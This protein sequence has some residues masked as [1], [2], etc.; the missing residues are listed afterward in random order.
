MPVRARTFTWGFGAT[1]RSPARLAAGRPVS[2][3]ADIAVPTAGLALRSTG[4]DEDPGR[5]LAD[6]ALMV[7]IAGG[8]RDAFMRL[9]QAQSPRLLRFA[10]SLLGSVAEAEELLQEG[11]LRL[12]QRA[13][14]WRPDGTIST[15][16]HRVIYRLAVDA[17]RRRRPSVGIDGLEDILAD[18][19]P[20][21]EERLAVSQESVRLRRAIDD[22]PERQ[23][24]ALLLCHFQE[25]GQAE[26]AS[27]MGIGEHAYE[28]LLARARR[29]LRETLNENGHA[30][31][32]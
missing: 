25:L 8:D 31:G 2:E 26:A 16:L 6:G 15:W 10:A 13:E 1:R 3:L 32:V 24:A 4:A 11:F 18:S 29:R 7:A 9:M 30:H 21:N 28:S 5:R 12:W 19:A 20:G 22:L 23:K 27:I 14:D 17:I